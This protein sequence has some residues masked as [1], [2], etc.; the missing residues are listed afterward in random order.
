[1]D[2]IGRISSQALAPR[3]VLGSRAPTE[4]GGNPASDV[5]STWG[6]RVTQGRSSIWAARLPA[7]VR[8]SATTASGSKSRSTGTV[9]RAA[10]TAAS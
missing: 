8:M 2:S 7:T 6:T 1:M 5:G 4:Y 10:R 3:R 9:S